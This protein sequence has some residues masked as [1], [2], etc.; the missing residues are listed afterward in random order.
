MSGLN[1]LVLAELRLSQAETR[2]KL[3][4][5]QATQRKTPNLIGRS[6]AQLT[7]QRQAKELRSQLDAWNWIVS[8]AQHE[9][10]ADKFEPQEGDEI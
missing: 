7:L 6:N 2:L 9:K 5:V 1:A 3:E 8:V 4:R 10:N